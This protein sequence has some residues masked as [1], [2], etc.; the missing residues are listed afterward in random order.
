[1]LSSERLEIAPLSGLDI[2]A[3]VAYRQHPDV[4][5]YQSWST[6][7]SREDA[8][9]LVAGQPSSVLPSPGEWMQFGLHALIGEVPVRALVGD[10]AVHADSTQPD[11]FELGVTMAPVRQG[12]GYASEALECVI[13][14]LFR[15]HRAH[16]IVMQGDSRNAPVLA[17]MRRL[18]FR[19]EGTVLEGDWFK[20]EWTSLERFAVLQREWARRAV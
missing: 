8:E 7:Y 5:R 17:L 3:F 14:W 11:T 16:R 1:M 20:G 13:D 15:D 10:V 18:R 19:H 9:A 2:P 12:A 4:A 6:H